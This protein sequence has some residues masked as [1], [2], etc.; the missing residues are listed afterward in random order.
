MLLALLCTALAWSCPSE[1]A[2]P[3]AEGRVVLDPASRWPEHQK[4]ALHQGLLAL[5]AAGAPPLT[6]V[7][8]PALP[9]DAAPCAV[10]LARAWARPAGEGLVLLLVEDPP[11]AALRGGVAAGWDPAGLHR[12]TAAAGVRTLGDAERGPAAVLQ[13][14]A[15]LGEGPPPAPPARPG[16]RLALVLVFGLALTAGSGFLAAQRPARPAALGS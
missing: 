1:Q 13:L 3:W 4:A 5:A 12:L 11:Q 9:G 8:A 6:V 14:A 2:A 16:A 15:R 10:A 7:L